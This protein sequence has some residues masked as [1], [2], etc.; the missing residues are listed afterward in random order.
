[1]SVPKDVGIVGFDDMPMASW[2]A[3]NL[4]TVRQ[5]VAEIIGTA[6]DLIVSIVE[7]PGRSQPSQLFAREAVVRETLRPCQNGFV[8]IRS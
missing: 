4:T 2:T 7:E 5:P 8:R 1:M 6:I 3:Y